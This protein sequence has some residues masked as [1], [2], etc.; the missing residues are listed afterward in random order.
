MSHAEECGTK[1]GKNLITKVTPLNSEN[2]VSTMNADINTERQKKR[3]LEKVNEI[4]E[5]CVK[6][7]EENK[8]TGSKL[9][10]GRVRVQSVQSQY[11]PIK[12]KV[13]IM[14]KILQTKTTIT[15][16]TILPSS[17]ISTKITIRIRISSTARTVQMDT[18]TPCALQE[19]VQFERMMC[20][21]SI[22]PSSLIIHGKRIVNEFL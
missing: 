5:S 2:S 7:K 16:A 19:D 15:S 4:I 17:S 6:L 3:L 8:V 10:K 22:I 11:I 21:V 12:V 9:E 14:V 13:K 1:G 20:L 18:R